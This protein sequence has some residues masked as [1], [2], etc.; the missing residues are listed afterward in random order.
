MKSRG[1]APARCYNNYFR[2]TLVLFIF[3][4]LVSRLALAQSFTLTDDLGYRLELKACPQRIV[5]LA[6]N[7]TEILFALGLNEQ[8]VGVTK[9]CDFPAEVRTR[10]RVGGLVDP[11]PEII[12]SIRP[13]LVLGFRGNP[14]NVLE[15]LRNLSF[16]LFVFEQGKNFD[17]L[18]LLISRIGQLTCRQKEAESLVNKMKRQ[19]SEMD[20]IVSRHTRRKRVFLT[21]PDQGNSLWTCGR[22]SYMTCLL[23]RAGA[24]SISADLPGSWLAINQEQLIVSD[25]EVILILSRDKKSFE[26]A[27]QT[28][29]KRPALRNINAL[30]KNNIFPL[31]ENI[32]SRF[33]PRLIEAYRILVLTL[34]P[35]NSGMRT[36]DK[37]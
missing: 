30:K 16:P 17:D 11:S 15:R 29:L 13:D 25:P 9:F 3:I 19:L 2:N 35:E 33:G 22:D 18:F 31:D 6:P 26:T 21:L 4:S 8:V 27:R 7:L 28:I 1:S 37:T 23:E 20:Q 5:S 34:Y 14:L 12:R 10:T 36:E 32:F 24:S